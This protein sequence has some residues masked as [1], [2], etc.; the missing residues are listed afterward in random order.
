MRKRL[1]LVLSSAAFVLALLGMTPI[2]EA[3][4]N[5]IPPRAGH[6]KTADYAK[7]AGAV[8][9][10]K[11]SKRPRVG[12]LVALGKDAKF[13]KVVGQVGP[14]GPQGAAGAQG[15]QGAK[16]D[17]GDQGAPGAAGVSGV[18]AYDVVSVNATLAASGTSSTTAQC[19]AGKNVLGGGVSPGLGNV[20]RSSPTNSNTAWT[21]RVKNTAAV[22][23]SMTVYAVCARVAS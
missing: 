8:N 6:A 22:N 16:G 10:L 23:T 21:A 5:A 11:A 15:P 17:K 2:G 9:G 13:P 4:R 7:N 3:A 1:P 18:S 19:P 12:W 20:E 14:Q